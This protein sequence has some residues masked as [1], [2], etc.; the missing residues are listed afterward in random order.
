[1][2]GM[3]QLTR[4]AIMHNVT[5][6]SRACPLPSLLQAAS[7]RHTPAVAT[8]HRSRC[9]GPGTSWLHAP[10]VPAPFATSRP[11]RQRAPLALATTRPSLLGDSPHSSSARCW[12]LT[13]L[14]T[15]PPRAPHAPPASHT[16]HGAYAPCA[17]HVHLL[18]SSPAPYDWQEVMRAGLLK[19]FASGTA[20]ELD[21]APLGQAG[22]GSSLETTWTLPT[23]APDDW[24]KWLQVERGKDMCS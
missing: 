21:L 1:M 2:F 18:S 13:P 15:P 19:T 9:R 5:Q 17:T 10:H 6:E 3:K 7:S 4:E 23:P 12:D 20:P 14:T 24:G 11:S 22:G 16:S 8:S